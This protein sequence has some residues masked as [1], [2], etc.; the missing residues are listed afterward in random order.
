LQFT[1]TINFEII[2]I[3]MVTTWSSIW[4]QYKLFTAH[5][6]NKNK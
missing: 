1:S 4:S 2:C 5:P 3:V 6:K